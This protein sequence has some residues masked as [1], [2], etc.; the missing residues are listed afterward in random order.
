MENHKLT[1]YN[2]LQSLQ[3]FPMEWSGIHW[4][5]HWGAYNPVVNNTSFI[6]INNSNE[7]HTLGYVLKAPI[8][9]LPDDIVLIGSTW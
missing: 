8:L 1:V 6:T 5:P 7:H 9:T 3:S 4:V 2:G